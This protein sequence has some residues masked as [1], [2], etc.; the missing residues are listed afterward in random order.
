M[1]T[2]TDI[3]WLAGLMEGEG[4][5]LLRKDGIPVITYNTTD[6]DVAARVNAL[7]SGMPQNIKRRQPHYKD[8]YRTSIYSQKACGWMMTLY[9]FMGARRKAKIACVVADW[10]SRSYSFR[11]PPKC[12]HAATDYYA[13]GYCY[14]CY[15]KVVHRRKLTNDGRTEAW[16]G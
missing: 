7:W 8:V 16:H 6:K 11:T 3:A 14:L 4:C 1:A 2:V 12:E 13:K 5:F 10:K 9:S 15:F